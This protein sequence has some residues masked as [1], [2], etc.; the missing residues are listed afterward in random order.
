MTPYCS[1]VSEEDQSQTRYDL[2]GI[3]NHCGTAW[4]GHY[5][6][7][8]RLLGNNDSAKTEIGK[9]KSFLKRK[10]VNLRFI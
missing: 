6:S 2:Y 3:I 5:T 1:S 8:G 7:Y 9:Q 10:K 4:F